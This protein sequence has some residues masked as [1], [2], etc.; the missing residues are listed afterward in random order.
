MKNLKDY[1][2]AYMTDTE[3]GVGRTLR[4]IIEYLNLSY[5]IVY[6]VLKKKAVYDNGEVVIWSLRKFDKNKGGQKN[7]KTIK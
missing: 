2:F 5:F 1:Y 3:M 4:P 6:R 7:G